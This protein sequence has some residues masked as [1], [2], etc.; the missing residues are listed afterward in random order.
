MR[1]CCAH[2][3][4]LSSHNSVNI[5]SRGLKFSED[6]VFWWNSLL[7]LVP[8]PIPKY[9]SLISMNSF[10]GAYSKKSFKKSQKFMIIGCG[11]N[12]N[13]KFYQKTPS[14]E[15]FSF[16]APILTELRLPKLQKCVQQT[17]IQLAPLQ[18]ISRTYLIRACNLKKIH[19]V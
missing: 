5:R 10:T 14:S 7:I 18:V 1:L 3:R 16:L 4:C 17:L 8:H 6:G 15:N 13:A 2:V 11:I 19:L 9:F 12:V